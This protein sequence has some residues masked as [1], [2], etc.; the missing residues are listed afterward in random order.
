MLVWCFLSPFLF[1]PLLLFLFLIQRTLPKSARISF[2]CFKWF[3]FY[4]QKVSCL[5][6]SCRRNYHGRC[7]AFFTSWDFE[8]ADQGSH[9]YCE[10]HRNGLLSS[11]GAASM[12]GSKMARKSKGKEQKSSLM[13]DL[14]L[15]Q[16]YL[17][18]F[19][20]LLNPRLNS[21]CFLTAP[22]SSD[23]EGASPSIS[24]VAPS[25]PVSDSSR[26]PWDTRPDEENSVSSSS[27]VS[28][29]PTFRIYGRSCTIIFVFATFAV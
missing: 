19:Y 23:P 15:V 8:R 16:E 25:A 9:Y 1:I 20:S 29:A 13:S 27:A 4:R 3:L 17:H 18:Y 5:E 7:A 11:N 2:G 10:S 6:T 26:D 12:K 28:D 24:V 21:S 14:N 22:R